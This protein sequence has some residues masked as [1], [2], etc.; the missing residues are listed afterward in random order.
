MMSSL[1]SWMRQQKDGRGSVSESDDGDASVHL[2][3]ILKLNRAQR[4][5]VGNR[6]G[7]SGKDN[8]YSMM[9]LARLM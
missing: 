4:R 1:G 7:A 9:L 5:E 3:L 8:A 2:S 6:W